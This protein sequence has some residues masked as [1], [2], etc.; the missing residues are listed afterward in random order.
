MTALE[1]HTQIM[2]FPV[3]DLPLVSQTVCAA[4]S[5]A[6]DDIADTAIQ[7]LIDLVVS[8]YSQI[9]QFVIFWWTK[10]PSAQLLSTDGGSSSALVAVRGYTSELQAV[11]LTAGIMFAAA[12]LALAKRGAAAGE[13][14]ESFLMLARAV[15]ASTLLGT[16]I[17]VGTGAGD[18]FSDWVLTD[19]ADDDLTAVAAR[20]TE[21]SVDTKSGL[22]GGVLLIIGLLGLISGLIQLVMLVIRQALLIM[23]VA[24]LPMAA[25]AAG[26]NPGGPA[27][28]KLLS[29]SLAVDRC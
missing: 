6:T 13:A 20:L 7:N 24:V 23:V 10:L 8:G 3:C 22:G 14:Q 25:A 27:Y 2:P 12:R 11:F 4:V 28:N 21:F 5:E 29:W 19:A 1:M 16:A 17:A 26:T 9:L 18:A 15:I